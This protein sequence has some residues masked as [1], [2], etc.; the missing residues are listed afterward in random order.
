MSATP[1]HSTALYID[2]ELNCWNGP[3]PAG[4]APEIIEIG[5]VEVDL[6]DLRL[7]REAAYF[8]RPRHLYVSTRCTNLTGIMQ[9]DLES[10]PRFPEVL[11]RFIADFA[12]AEK[13]CCCWGRDADLLQAECRK[14]QVPFPLRNIRDI[15][16][17]FWHLSLRRD[18]PGLQTAVELM[19]LVFSGVPHTAL[20]DARNLAL[21]H[22]ALL[23][24]Q[25]RQIEP[26]APEVTMPVE[27]TR[28][29]LLDPSGRQA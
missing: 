26:T 10:A 13:L 25:R 8:I 1:V 29:T 3:P 18:Q 4:R 22:T 6:N 28:S 20:A 7:V 21:V 9:E 27:T 16:Q 17:L 14:H 19:G 5:A 11:A 12:P 15:A 2:L 23:R 24:R